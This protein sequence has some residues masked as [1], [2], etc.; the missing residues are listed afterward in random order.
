MSV[1]FALFLAGVQPAP[2]VVI[3]EADTRRDGPAPHGEI[4]QS[5]A[6][7]ISDAVPAPRS[8]EFRKRALHVGSA[9]G[10]HLIDHDEIY[11]VVSGTGTVHS[12]GEER[13]L[14]PGMAAWLYKG[15]NVGIRQTGD[16]PLVLI[17]AYPN[18]PQN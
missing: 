18:I 3:D 6:W 5:T 17:I 9:I 15:A 16:E 1:I 2:M 4:G 10:V 13:P 8:F 14:K 12:D 11:Y 7:R